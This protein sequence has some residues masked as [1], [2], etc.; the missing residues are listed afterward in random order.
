MN[1]EPSIMTIHELLELKKREMLKVNPEYQRGAVWTKDQKKRL[2][3]SVLRGYPIPLMYL[4]RKTHV[5]GSLRSDVLEVIDGQQRINAIYEFSEG[6][7]P[8]FDPVAD[9]EQA[10]FPNFIKNQP[11]EW[12]RKTFDTL[13]EGLKT[14][15]LDTPLSVVNIETENDNEARD[16]FIR[17]QAGTP[18]NSQ[19]KRDAWPGAVN[20]FILKT[21]GKPEIPKYPGHEFFGKVMGAKAD[22]VKHRQFCA[23][24]VLLF[25][26]RHESGGHDFCD[27]NAQAIDNF[28]YQRLDFDPA[29]ETAKRFTLILDLLTRLLGDRQRR[30][31]KA[32]EVL[33]LILFTDTLLDEYVRD[34][35]EDLVRAFDRFLERHARSKATRYDSIP[36]EYWLRYGILTRTNADRGDTIRQRHEFFA[37]EMLLAMPNIR[38]KDPTRLFGP[39]EREIVYYRDNKKCAV[40]RGT[41]PWDEAH[42]HHVEQHTSGGKTSLDNAVLVHARCHPKGHAAEEFALRWAEE[43]RSARDRQLLQAVKEDDDEAESL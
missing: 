20:E 19:E 1:R 43:Q 21:A 13:P 15:F 28:Y 27:I 8:L 30:N 24:W 23:Q 26:A 42:I 33:H 25:F 39:V 16:L 34:W 9:E 14:R 11:C 41:V 29:S 12:A 35:E 38:S 18:L 36:D 22:R 4:H 6:S 10:R 17:L 31:L 5:V 2:I 3:D 37:R 40:C 7:F 32:H